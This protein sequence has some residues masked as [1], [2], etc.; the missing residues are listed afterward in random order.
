MPLEDELQRLVTATDPSAN[1]A[2]LTEVGSDKRTQVLKDAAPGEW[3][4]W[5]PDASKCCAK[6]S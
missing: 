2:T 5:V 3:G 4:A 6:T 1:F